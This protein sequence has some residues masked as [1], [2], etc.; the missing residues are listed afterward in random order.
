MPLAQNRTFQA[1][2]GQPL[3]KFHMKTKSVFLVLPLVGIT[4]WALSGCGGSGVAAVSQFKGAFKAPYTSSLATAGTYEV[5][6]ADDAT[7]GVK[8]VDNTGTYSGVGNIA[9]SGQLN[10]TLSNGI[11]SINVASFF[12]TVAG[13]MGATLEIT[14][15]AD[16]AD[17]AWTATGTATY[18]APTIGVVY[19]GTYSGTTTGDV[20]G[21]MAV[22]AGTDGSVQVNVNSATGTYTGNG[23]INNLGNL[24]LFLTGSGLATG[25]TISFKGSFSLTG[26]VITNL[27][28]FEGSY[29][30]SAGGTGSGNF[31]STSNP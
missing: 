25:K 8:V 2:W 5:V 29:T 19:A 3:G 7:V 4:A 30:I 6:V 12:S 17:P 27:K 28:R 11:R 26:T 10:T 20:A 22:T 31:A 23:N 24:N 9:S 18:L 1:S 15:A 13:P 16:G 21:T 14:A